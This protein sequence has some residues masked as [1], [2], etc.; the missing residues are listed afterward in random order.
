MLVFHLMCSLTV[1]I[2]VNVQLAIEVKHYTWM[3]FVALF[4]GAYMYI[5]LFSFIYFYDMW[6]NM[7]LFSL[8]TWVA[9]YY[10]AWTPAY[11][12]PIFWFTMIMAVCICTVPSVISQ[13]IH[14]NFKPS[15][16]EHVRRMKKGG[17][18]PGDMS[19]LVARG[20]RVEDQPT[21]R[22]SYAFDQSRAPKGAFPSSNVGD[23][24]QNANQR[25][26][27]YYCLFSGHPT[28]PCSIP[29]FTP[30]TLVSPLLPHLPLYPPLLPHLPLPSLSPSLPTV[31]FFLNRY[32]PFYL[33]AS[34]SL[35][36][37]C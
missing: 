30:P 18:L 6:F 5:C 24:Q 10:G 29:P 33:T 1:A 31:T 19:S 21:T 35:F 23:A 28:H 36:P 11:G 7:Q 20:A 26:V 34:M 13:F 15:P 32:C 2:T 27:L 17:S 3:M 16:S 14:D 4:Y 25:G 12:S 8:N 22:S 9:A 37:L